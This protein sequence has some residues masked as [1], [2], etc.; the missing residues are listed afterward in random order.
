M[1]PAQFDLVVVANRLPVD[2]SLDEVG[3]PTWSRSPGGLVTAL[4]PVMAKTEGAW[5]GWGGQP[6]L[7]LDPFEVDGTELV[8][9]PLSEDEV[10]HYY[11]GFANDTL[12][13]LYHDVIASPAFHRHWWDAYQRVNR[14]FAEAAAAKA[15]PGATVWVHDYQ[16]QLVPKF[17]RELRPDLRIGYFHHIPFPPLE[18]FAQL[19]WRLQVVEGLL[20]ADL[21]GF[22]RGGD[23]A[24]FVRVVR[25]LTDLTT[26]GQVVTLSKHGRVERHVRASSFPISIDSHAFDELARTPDVLKRSREIRKELGDPEVLL[27]GVDRLDYTKGIRH[28]LKAYGELLDDGRLSPQSTTFVQVASPSRENVGAYQQLRDD[29]E[30]LVG[31]INGD[32]GQVG[33]APVQYLHQSYPME[34]MAALYLAADVMLVT[35]LRDGMNLVAKEYV[36]ARSD[37]RGALVLSE[38]TGAADELTGAILINP[39]DIDG[40]KD[41][42]TYAAHLDPREA[43][44]RM[45]RLRRRVLSHDVAAWSEQFLAVLTAVPNRQSHV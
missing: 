9:V 40:M 28:R 26:R 1:A 27:L 18:I 5:V 35:A 3:E 43:R 32:H 41:A 21:V 12:W 11:E 31:R 2:L 14:R 30:L 8:P 17:L 39:H 22:Q 10:E 44:K 23:A 20:G 6:G 25:R 45:R 37:D 13:P 38:F 16:L 15:A 29:V 42:I 33:H 4:A 34:E 24:N 19:P 36:A 7:E